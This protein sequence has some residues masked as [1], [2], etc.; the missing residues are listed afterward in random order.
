VA[1][2]HAL[3][4]QKAWFTN[5]R[6]D[7]ASRFGLARFRNGADFHGTAVISQ[8]RAEIAQLEELRRRFG[9]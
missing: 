2:E 5:S 6:F 7:G 1:F 9:S 3:F 8:K 4:E